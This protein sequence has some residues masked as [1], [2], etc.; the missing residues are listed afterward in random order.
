MWNKPAALE[1]IAVVV[2]VDL[3]GLVVAV[4]VEHGMMVCGVLW[5]GVMCCGML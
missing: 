4:T 2:A 3:P 5:R 1:V